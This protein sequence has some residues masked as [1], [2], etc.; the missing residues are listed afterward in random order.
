MKYFRYFPKTVD[1]SSRIIANLSKKITISNKLKNESVLYYT[2]RLNDGE[3]LDTLS[4]R[5]YGDEQYHWVIAIINGMMDPRFEVPLSYSEFDNFLIDKYGSTEIA[6]SK[7]HHYIDAVG[8]IVDEFTTP[9]TPVYCYEYE[10]SVNEA[11]R[12]IKLVRKE[13]V[14]QFVEELKRL[15]S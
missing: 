8:N 4:K 6:M 5:A 10:E 7:I 15:M 2:Y 9:R 14:S 3:R 1:E 11:K 13:Y 12:S